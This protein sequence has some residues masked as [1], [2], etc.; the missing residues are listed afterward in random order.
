MADSD[1]SMQSELLRGSLISEAKPVVSSW[2]I[3]LLIAG[4]TLRHFS[5]GDYTFVLTAGAGVQCLGF[6][7]L[8]KKVDAAR[9]AAGVSS[10]MLEMFFLMLIFRLSSTL[11]MEG[12]LP[13]DRSGDHVYQ[14]ADVASLVLVC[15]LLWRVNKTY[16]NTYDKEHDTMEVWKAVPGVIVA[17]MMLHGRMNQSWFFDTTWTIGMHLDTI[18][19]LPQYWLFVQKG[20]EVDAAIGHF[21]ACIVGSRAL[22]FTFWYYGYRALKPKRRDGGGPNIVGYMVLASHALQLLLSCDFMFHYLRSCWKKVKF[23]LPKGSSY[24]V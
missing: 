20:G 4:V 6:W 19:M 8:L 22:S 21:V 16:Q 23:M 15:A 13:V 17:G 9:S 11:V 5:D 24:D 2:I 10:K 14:A 18:A 1:I 3:F 7:I 12:Y